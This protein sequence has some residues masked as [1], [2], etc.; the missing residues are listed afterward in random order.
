MGLL[1]RLDPVVLAVRRARQ[2]ARAA[3]R[4]SQRTLTLPDGREIVYYDGDSGETDSGQ[5]DARP[6]VL[7]IHG[8]GASKDHWPH[9]VKPLA[10]RLRAIVP[11][12]PGF[13]ESDRS[14][15]ADYSM[16]AQG[17]NVIAIA[18]ALGLDRFHLVGQSMGGRVVAEVAARHPDRLH[19]LWLLAP[20]GTEGEKPSEMIEGLLAGEGIPLFGRTPEEYAETVAFTMSRPPKIPSLALRVLAAENAVDYDLNRE[21]FATMSWGF[22]SSPSTEELLR[23][24]R[25]P[26]LVTWGADD[27]VLHPSG[28]ATLAEAIPGAT[29]HR[30]PDTGHVPM[31]EDPKAAA[32]RYLAFLDA[33]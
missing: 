9:L 21:I 27:R 18:D 12:L 13:G 5:G 28:A 15:E 23:D 25:V 3:A 22:A 19:S 11:D 29:V 20:A 14:P 30:M 10:G 17:E 26:T 31:F 32:A 33:L 1:S 24:L 8:I 6:P 7:F 2:A 4:L 16:E